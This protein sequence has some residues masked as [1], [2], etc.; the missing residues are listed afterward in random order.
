MTQCTVCQAPSDRYLCGSERTGSGCL[1]E[2]LRNLESLPDLVAELDLTLSGQD[3]VARQS[4]GFVRNGGDEQP[5]PVNLGA[6][7]VGSHTRGVLFSWVRAL[8]EDNANPNADGSIPQV[9]IE[10]TIVGAAR[11]LSRHPNWLAIY[12]AA[13]ELWVEVRDEVRALRRATDIPRDSRVYLGK[14]GAE[15]PAEDPDESGSEPVVCTEELWTRSDAEDVV[16]P[17]CG[18]QWGA[19]ARRVWLL[20]YAEGTA[21][22]VEFLSGL[23]SLLGFSVTAQ[24]VR[25]L[26]KSKG[27]EPVTTV[28][29]GKRTYR[30]GAVMSALMGE[31]KSE[32]A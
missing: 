7:D 1:G 4:V 32:A 29:H 17:T 8:W 16:C 25:T 31:R 21:G 27:I 11:W 20:A 28:D 19:E 15:Y 26:I 9:D 12:P 2:L 13:D 18:A 6:S 23:L 10:P 3:K 24:E 22:T 30:V 14:C 5:L